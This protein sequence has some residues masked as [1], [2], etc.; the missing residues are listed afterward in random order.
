M[1][2]LVWGRWGATRVL[3]RPASPGTG[4]IAGGGVRAVMESAGVADVL[5]K[6]VGSRNPF[7]VV[8]ATFDAIDRLMT[9]GQVQR[10]RGVDMKAAPEAPEAT[11][12]PEAPEGA[13]SPAETENAEKAGEP[14]EAAV[15]E[16]DDS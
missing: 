1:P 4:V 10:L 11:E 12:A 5:T 15:A 2:H 13:E 6:I 14:A 16:G 3:L 7:N 9:S 8:R